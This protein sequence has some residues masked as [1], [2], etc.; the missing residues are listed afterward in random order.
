MT[1]PPTAGWRNVPTPEL[2]AYIAKGDWVY[3]TDFYAPTDILLLPVIDRAID[4]TGS[5]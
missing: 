3:L 2:D 4:R 5:K 1:T